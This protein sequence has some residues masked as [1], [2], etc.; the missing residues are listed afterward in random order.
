MSLCLPG[1]QGVF[2]VWRL[3]RAVFPRRRSK[4]SA[5]IR[6]SR[7]GSFDLCFTSFSLT[8]CSATG[9]GQTG[10]SFLTCANPKPHPKHSD[11]PLSS[12]G[13][14]VPHC[15][16]NDLSVHDPQL[17]IWQGPVDASHI[18]NS[19]ALVPLVSLP[20]VDN[21][22]EAP[23]GFQLAFAFAPPNLNS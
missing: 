15:C 10:A 6:A 22:A 17:R 16:N 8:F 7:V 18:N 4:L 20:V 13:A 19:I 9:E 1:G 5:E 2:G 11:P 21:E 14:P 12:A 23:F 3:A